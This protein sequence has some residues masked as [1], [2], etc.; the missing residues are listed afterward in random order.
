MSFSLLPL[1]ILRSI[2]SPSLSL[3]LYTPLYSSSPPQILEPSP[4][5][6]SSLP[7]PTLSDLIHWSNGY[8]DPYFGNSGSSWKGQQKLCYKVWEQR[9]RCCTSTAATHAPFGIYACRGVHQTAHSTSFS[10]PT[11]IHLGTVMICAW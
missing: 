9:V 11:R 3:A 2:L 10:N 7:S 4:P 1:S 6:N 8:Q 5:S